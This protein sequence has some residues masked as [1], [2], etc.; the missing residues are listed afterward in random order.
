MAKARK[1][2]KVRKVNTRSLIVIAVLACLLLAGVSVTVFAK[3]YKTGYNKGMAVASGFYFGSNYMSSVDNIKG[4]T[5]EEIAQNHIDSIVVSANRTP[6]KGT[7]VFDFDVEV[8]NY[9]NQLLYNDIDLNVEYQVN[10]MLLDEPKGASYTVS[11][12][13]TTKNL[14][15][16]G[17]R[18]TVVS[19]TGTL[20]GGIL[21]AN[22]YRLAVGMQDA[23]QYVPANILMVAYPIGPDYLINTK[24][25][26]GIVKANYEDKEFKIES[27][28]GFTVAKTTDYET[29][30]KEAINK[31]SG[32]VY[33]LLTSGSYTGAGSTETRKKIRLK[34]D[35]KMFT[36]NENDDHYKEVKDDTSK[37]YTMSEGG[38]DWQVMEIEV[39]PYASI[40]FVFFRNDEFMT[41]IGSMS[42]TDFENSVKAEVIP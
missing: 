34:W 22:V 21:R 37:Y 29:N 28:T 33:Q 23:N 3:Y 13:V 39:L 6:W 32:F 11:D 42:K 41:K 20:P 27:G 35:S 26:A 17:G 8:R 18:G 25:I 14:G 10:F 12:G 36:I 30:W 19:F 38:I 5:M 16:T 4:L 1:P 31:E 15:W 2:K 40:K 24:C 7:N 9:D